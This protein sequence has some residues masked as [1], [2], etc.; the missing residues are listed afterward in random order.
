MT[1]AQDLRDYDMASKIAQIFSGAMFSALVV[2]LVMSNSTR[3]SYI[4]KASLEKRLGVCCQINTIVASLSAFLNFFQLTEVDNW[5]LV[6]GRSMVVDVARP[7]EWILTCPLMQLNLVLMGGSRIPEY[8]RV[9]MPGLSAT[10]LAFGSV[11]L[12]LDK[13]LIFLFWG[14]GICFH[15]TQMYF[16]FRQIR[17]HSNG[18]ESVLEGDSE[19]RKATLILMATWLPFPIWYIL[20][21]E[22]FGVI[23]NIAVIQMGWAF[24]NVTAKFSLIFYMQRVKDNYCN[25]LKTK[26]E[27]KGTYSAG[28]NLM[29][30]DDDDTSDVANP[31]L[32][33]ELSA[34]VVETMSDLGMAYNVERF[35]TLLKE[36]GVNCLDDLERL[37]EETCANA[38]LPWDL[39][40]PVKRRYKVWKL[41]MVDDAEK[42]LEKGE[43]HYK[44][45]PANNQTTNLKSSSK[46]GQFLQ[47]E[48]ASSE[49]VLEGI[50]MPPTKNGAIK[51]INLG[52]AAKSEGTQ[53]EADP[54][55]R[56]LHQPYA[57]AGFDAETINGAVK[58]AVKPMAKKLEHLENKM[59]DKFETAIESLGRKFERQMETLVE[60]TQDK[61][62]NGLQDMQR[63]RREAQSS[64]EAKID[65]VLSSQQKGGAT[66]SIEDQVKSQVAEATLK[67]QFDDLAEKYLQLQT[68]VAQDKGAAQVAQAVEQSLDAVTQRMDDFQVTL[69]GSLVSLGGSIT[70]MMDGWAQHTLQ[71]AKASAFTLQTKMAQME[72]AQNKRA[73]E[74]EQNITSKLQKV[75]RESMDGV[76]GAM[77][78]QSKSSSEQLQVCLESIK[79][80]GLDDRSKLETK[81][82][83][84]AQSVQDLSKNVETGMGV[85]GNSL[86]GQIENLQSS[87]R[88]QLEG[89][90]AAQLSHHHKTESSISM[91]VDSKLTG[92]KQEL[93]VESQKLAENSQMHVKKQMDKY[94]E[95]IMTMLSSAKNGAQSQK[96]S[97]EEIESAIRGVRAGTDECVERL[98]GLYDFFVAGVS[99]G[100]A[101]EPRPAS[102]QRRG[103]SGGLS[104][105][106]SPVRRAGSNSGRF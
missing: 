21:P 15:C 22:G 104:A 25:R 43:R 97:T 19:F 17:E 1:S 101:P 52:F 28:A 65:F 82:T 66:H 44:V 54:S 103:S 36:A 58:E 40:W 5:A 38:Q 47:L 18:V 14:V 27:M 72:D 78:M 102:A 48:E 93:A 50:A 99:N 86:R 56:A 69:K 3:I 77:S 83:Q 100:T 20:S 106:S 41:E 26:R 75:I 87:L 94:T 29:D 7:L 51:E 89:V 84:T 12:F 30:A 98:V 57:S 35:L 33:G 13:P 60:Q 23:D 4:Q 6:G 74:I 37:N 88:S 80:S 24:L 73:A 68:K 81:L 96:Q 63:S 9:L 71:D 79:M 76:Y 46:K 61:F 10:V 39:V 11:T 16:N 85:V 64:L 70:E 31:R 2:Y 8:R 42:G 90:Q 55:P 67:K 62:D 59:L 91:K 92:M 49:P 34:C 45:S 105:G 53:W 32:F 95:E